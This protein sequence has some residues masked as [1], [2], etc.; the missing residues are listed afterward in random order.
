MKKVIFATFVSLSSCV[1]RAPTE[2][3]LD[4]RA[5]L[6]PATLAEEHRD[7]LKDQLT[8]LHPVKGQDKPTRLPL[9]S[10]AR[11]ERVWVYDQELDG[12]Y[13]L[14][15]TYLYLEVEPGRWVQEEGET[16]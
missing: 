2:N 14:Q 11:V 6:V 5:G 9:R 10:T 7:E 4:R 12:G 3:E 1:T 15:G 13:F 16:P 8:G